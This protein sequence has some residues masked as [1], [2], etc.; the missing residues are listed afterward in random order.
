MQL[1]SSSLSFLILQLKVPTN[2]I[3]GAETTA[4]CLA[5]TV[6]YLLKTP[7]ALRKL[8]HEIRTHYFHYTEIDATSAQQLPYLQAALHESLRIYPPGSLGFPRISPGCQIDGVWI[9]RGTEVYTSAFSVTH[10]ESYFQD[11]ERYVP[12]R[13][14][15]GDASAG[16]RRDV[17]EAS[18]PFSLGYRACIGRKYVA[19]SSCNTFI[20][21]FSPPA[22][23]IPPASARSVFGL[24]EHCDPLILC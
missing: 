24:D 16:E 6:Y 4:T 9:P 23:S 20:D 5:A 17:K 10:D 1:L 7:P 3:A 15:D 11:P 19:L 18:Q 21:P 13:W 8:E 22:L 14:M 2:S 12:E